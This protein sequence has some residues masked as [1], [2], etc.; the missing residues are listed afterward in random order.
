MLIGQQLNAERSDSTNRLL[1]KTL[2]GKIGNK[3]IFLGKTE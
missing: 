3:I 2:H 1:G